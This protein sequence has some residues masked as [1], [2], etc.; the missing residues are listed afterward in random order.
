MKVCGK[1]FHLE[2][3]RTFDSRKK[4][5]M[6]SNELN[7]GEGMLFVFREASPQ[8]FWMKNVP[9]GLDILFF[10]S[11]GR[12]LNWHTMKPDTPMVLDHKKPRYESSSPAQFVVEVAPG[13]VK[14][15]PVSDVKD[16]RLVPLPT[17]G[18]EVE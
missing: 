1:D 7:D 16:C 18:P 11:Q 10:N 12:L 14:N 5:L 8:V 17:I 2:I 3:A 4:G 13:S 15:F 6:F 9:V